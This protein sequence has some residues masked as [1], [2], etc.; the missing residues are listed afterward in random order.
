MQIIPAIKKRPRCSSMG[1]S[2]I[3][4][5]HTQ[6][7]IAELNLGIKLYSVAELHKIGLHLFRVFGILSNLSRLNGIAYNYIDNPEHISI[8]IQ[9]QYQTLAN[10]GR[11]MISMMNGCANAISAAIQLDQKLNTDDVSAILELSTDFCESM[12]GLLSNF[13]K[14]FLAQGEFNHNPEIQFSKDNLPD[15]DHRLQKIMRI[16]YESIEQV[17]HALDVVRGTLVNSSPLQNYK[18]S[19]HAGGNLQLYWPED[20]P[21]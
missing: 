8:A 21:A 20:F 6:N 16:I 2:K 3:I 19:S 14:N 1:H 10:L 13:E 7:N 17:H 12:Q 15:S 5:I 9:G 11:N 4:K 18:K